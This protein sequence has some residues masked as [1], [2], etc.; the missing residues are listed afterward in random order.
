MIAKNNYSVA[1]TKEDT[2][3]NDLFKIQLNSMTE[4]Y[5]FEWHIH[6]VNS[7]NPIWMYEAGYVQ[8]GWSVYVLIILN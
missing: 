7:M 3:S 1:Q 4:N 6:N 5:S 2:R 8:F